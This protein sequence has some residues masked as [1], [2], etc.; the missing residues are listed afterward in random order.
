[1][2]NML[3]YG[4]IASILAVSGPA[5]A[6]DA[7]KAQEMNQERLRIQEENRMRKEEALGVQKETREEGEEM[8]T[9]HRMELG[10]ATMALRNASS[11]EEREAAQKK[12]RELRLIQEQEKEAFRKQNAGNFRDMRMQKKQL[13]QSMGAA[14]HGR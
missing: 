13:H 11:K 3:K 6:Q 9:R 7:V 1:M 10:G 5:L 2:R 12:L 8:R 4:V 14:K